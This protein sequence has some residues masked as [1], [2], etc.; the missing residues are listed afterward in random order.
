MGEIERLKSTTA[1]PA[2]CAGHPQAL[3]I[4]TAMRNYGLMVVDNGITGGI[5]ATADAR[6]NTDDLTCLSNL[7]LSDFEPV[8]VSSKMIDLNSSQVRP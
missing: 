4:I 5:V 7:K 1:T 3:V 2:A 8:N 6:W